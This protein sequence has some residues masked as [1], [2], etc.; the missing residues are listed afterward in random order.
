VCWVI[1]GSSGSEL[2]AG[3]GEGE[4]EGGVEEGM[5]GG[6]GE[7]AEGVAEGGAGVNG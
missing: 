2:V 5:G 1:R 7:A 3:W 6:V 4:A